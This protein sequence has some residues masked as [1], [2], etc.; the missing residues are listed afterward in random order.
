MSLETW[1]LLG[2]VVT[3]VGLPLAI[4]VFLYGSART[5]KRR[6]TSRSLTTTGIS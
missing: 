5:R 3:V 1:E 4:A 2:Y 6:S